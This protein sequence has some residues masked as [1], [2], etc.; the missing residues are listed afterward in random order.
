[1]FYS[2]PLSLSHWRSWSNLSSFW[3][4]SHCSW[5]ELQEEVLW[6]ILASNINMMQWRPQS[7]R[8]TQLGTGSS[9]FDSPWDLS[10]SWR[11]TVCSLLLLGHVPK[12]CSFLIG[13]AEK[14]QIHVFWCHAV[15]NKRCQFLSVSFKFRESREPETLEFLIFVYLFA[16]FIWPNN[17][18]VFYFRKLGVH[19]HGP[20]Q[21]KCLLLRN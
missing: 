6:G 9:C 12:S 5:L 19:F 21:L 4:Y 3:C 16:A 10:I 18:V 8:G 1:M 14:C 17:T 15:E 11:E 13:T 7:L 20:C 2:F